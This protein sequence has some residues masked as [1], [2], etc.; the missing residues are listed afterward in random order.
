MATSAKQPVVGVHELPAQRRRG[1]GLGEVLALDVLRR[2]TL[3][4][5][6][7]GLDGRVERV[8]VL[9]SV[10]DLTGVRPRELVLTS[11]L[12]LREAS[13]TQLRHLVPGLVAADAAGLALSLGRHVD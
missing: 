10:N 7:S 9:E 3:I 12:P 5:G 11:G 4:G 13:A 1:L 8:G 2:A 6:R